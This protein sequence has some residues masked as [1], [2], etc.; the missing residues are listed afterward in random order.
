MT[1]NLDLP[2]DELHMSVRSYS[3]LY[4]AGNVTLG[5]LVI[6]TEESL[7]QVF[8][9]EFERVVEV[10]RVLARRGLHLADDE[11]VY[12]GPD[13][14]AP[15]GEEAWG[16]V[17]VW[18]SEDNALEELRSFVADAYRR[19]GLERELVRAKSITKEDLG[20]N[21]PPEFSP[22]DI[23]LPD[24]VLVLPEEADGWFAVL[25]SELEWTMP[26]QH[27][28]A[29]TLSEGYPVVTITSAGGQ[30]TE[31]TRYMFGEVL[32]TRITGRSLPVDP[33]SV[34]RRPLDLTWFTLHGA[35]GDG[36]ELYDVIADADAFG[37]LTGCETAGFRAAFEYQEE[38]DDDALMLFR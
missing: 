17:Y 30:Y 15:P 13:H 25:S 29:M 8:R 5:D 7:T 36:A 33:S 18:S 32:G 10:R 22:M 21:F 34:I 1:Q 12:L 28:L 4:E 6:N 23:L 20:A 19:F 9:G 2:L 37:A 16:G 26:T 14:A 11:G 24:D 27:P 3:S 38:W 31:I 35:M